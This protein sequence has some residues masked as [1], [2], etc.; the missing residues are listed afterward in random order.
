MTTV[1]EFIG[2]HPLLMLHFQGTDAFS[3]ALFPLEDGFVTVG[4]PPGP[5]SWE[6]GKDAHVIRSPWRVGASGVELLVDDPRG[7]FILTPPTLREE[8]E[9]AK[10][11]KVTDPEVLVERAEYAKFWFPELEGVI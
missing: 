4:A 2:Q 1:A 11:N 3:G 7:T 10:A 8:V 6:T 9:Q 5:G